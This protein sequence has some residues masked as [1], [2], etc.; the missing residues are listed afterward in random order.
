MILKSDDATLYATRDLGT[1][2]FRLKKYGNDVVVINEVGAEQSLYWQQIFTAEEMLGWY[3]KGQRYH[4]KHGLFRFN[5]SK[6]STRK[7][8]VIWLEDVLNNAVRKAKDVVE[9]S[10]TVNNLSE[11]EKI[12]IAETVGIGAIKYSDLSHDPISDVVFDWNKALSF[13]GDTGPYLQ[14]TYVRANNILKKATKWKEVFSYEKLSNEEKKL[15]SKLLQFPE[16][17]EKSS[18]ELKPH[19]ICS[20]AHELSSLFNTF[21]HMHPVLQIQDKNL[22]Q[23]R[24]TLV[25]AFTYTLKNCLELLGIETPQAM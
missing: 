13:E 17:V 14:Y 25:K 19:H 8:N 18:R 21:Y 4:L 20:Y 23:F 9:K 5:D 11:K 15:F 16:I 10:E 6:M 22:K 24:L 7:G 3:K 2:K 1:D 12:N